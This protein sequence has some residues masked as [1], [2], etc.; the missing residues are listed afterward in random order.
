MDTRLYVW[1]YKRVPSFIA[2]K[3]TKAEKE[4]YL[5]PFD[6]IKSKNRSLKIFRGGYSQKKAAEYMN[7][8]GLSLMEGPDLYAITDKDNNTI[9]VIWFTKLGDL[10]FSWKYNNNHK[11]KLVKIGSLQNNDLFELVKEILKDIY[12]E[13]FDI[14]LNHFF[15]EWKFT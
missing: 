1:I 4:E 12:N 8:D 5:I 11:T 6:D 2:L 13:D 3:D 14:K 9:L 15:Y 7:L 10:E